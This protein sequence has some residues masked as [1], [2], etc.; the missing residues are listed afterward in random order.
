MLEEQN[1]RQRYEYLRHLHSYGLTR[2]ALTIEMQFGYGIRCHTP[3]DRTTLVLRGKLYSAIGDFFYDSSC[4][5]V[6]NSQ[7]NKKCTLAVLLY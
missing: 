3:Q 6:Y 7:G 1:F 4:I 5:Y 2:Q